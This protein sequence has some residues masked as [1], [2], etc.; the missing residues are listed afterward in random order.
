[1]LVSER[2]AERAVA[3]KSGATSGGGLSPTTP[4]A[5][6]TPSAAWSRRVR[7]SAGRFRLRSPAFGWCAGAR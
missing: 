4:A 1:M 5:D 3:R 6:L 7:G 2:Q